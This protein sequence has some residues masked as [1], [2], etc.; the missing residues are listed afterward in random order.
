MTHGATT[1]PGFDQLAA[2]G[3]GRLGDAASASIEEHLATCRDCCESLKQTPT[4]DS[5]VRLLRDT[6]TLGASATDVILGTDTAAAEQ[7]VCVKRVAGIP[8][9]LVEHPRYRVIRCVGQGGMGIV[10]EAEHRLMRRR[11]ALKIIKPQWLSHPGAIAR[12]RSEVQAAAK[13]IHPHIVTAF[14]AEQ[15]GDLHFLVMEFVDGVTLS[16]LVSNGQMLPVAMACD[17]IREAALGLQHAHEHGLVHRDI[18]PGNLID[19]KSVV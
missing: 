13:L 14:D 3:L 19:R 5:Y 18:K 12:F 6:T 2:F 11:V 4:D 15:A 7:P 16:D 17:L 1:H 10:F 9:A 8:E